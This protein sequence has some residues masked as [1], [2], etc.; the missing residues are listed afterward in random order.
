M[1]SAFTRRTQSEKS[2]LSDDVEGKSA[3]VNRKIRDCQKGF[4]II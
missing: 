2:D 3:W 4:F 1:T